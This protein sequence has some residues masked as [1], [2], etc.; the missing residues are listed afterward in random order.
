MSGAIF[1]RYAIHVTLSRHV[2]GDDYIKC[3]LIKISLDYCLLMRTLKPVSTTHRRQDSQLNASHVMLFCDSDRNQHYGDHVWELK[4]DLP[5]VPAHAIKWAAEEL[6]TS[7]E[8]A[9][10]LLSPTN[11]VDSAGAWDDPQ[12]VSDLYQECGEPVGF[13]TPDGA[14]V[15]DRYSVDLVKLA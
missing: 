1:K 15:L 14:V 13:K 10:D 11:I 7:E 5:D 2:A 4:S 12:F 9:S 8:E 3:M 6:R